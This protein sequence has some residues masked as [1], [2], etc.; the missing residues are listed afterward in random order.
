MHIVK[1]HLKYFVPSMGNFTKLGD[2][3]I[4][5][6]VVSIVIQQQSQ[7]TCETTTITSFPS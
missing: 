4:L 3:N 7:C 5:L 1:N 6:R 2:V